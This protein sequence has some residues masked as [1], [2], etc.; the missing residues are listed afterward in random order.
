MT[1][2]TIIEYNLEI[3]EEKLFD[4]SKLNNIKEEDLEIINYHILKLSDT[5]KEGLFV[6][7]SQSDIE[8]YINEEFDFNIEDDI[9]ID[10]ETELYIIEKIRT[11]VIENIQKILN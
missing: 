6:I 9:E 11:K 1:T 2:I 3:C 7:D 5:L 4:I 8:E 10:E